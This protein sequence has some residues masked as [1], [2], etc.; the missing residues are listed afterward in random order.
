MEQRL[1]ELKN[2]I[3]KINTTRERLLGKKQAILESLQK[4][5]YN[6]PQDAEEALI[7]L[8]GKKQNI[9]KE[10]NETL[11]ELEVKVQ[12]IENTL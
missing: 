12:E 9:E 5:G 3:N 11:N 7:K 4:A 6:S 1:L 8:Q 2:R 10:F